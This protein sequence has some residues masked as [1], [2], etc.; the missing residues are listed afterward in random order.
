M[1]FMTNG[2]EFFLTILKMINCGLGLLL[3]Y[4]RYLYIYYVYMLNICAE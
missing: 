1:S 3:C 2:V 4:L